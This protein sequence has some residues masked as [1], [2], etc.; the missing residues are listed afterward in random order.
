MPLVLMQR[1]WRD[2]P[3]YKDTE[4]VVYHYP[5]M[6]FDEIRGREEF[7][8]YRPA[9]GAP[10]GHGSTY[11]GCGV[12]GDWY[13]D[14]YDPNHRYVDIEKAVPFARPVPFEDTKGAMFESQLPSRNA[15]QGRS[16]RHIGELDFFRI[17]QA[18]GLTSAVFDGAPTVGDVLGGRAS[19]LLVPPRDAFRPLAVVPEGTGYRPNENGRPDIF[20][21]ASLQERARADHQETLKLFKNLVDGKGGTCL[22]NNNVDLLAS[23][24]EQRLLVE[25]K[26]LTRPVSTVD[27]MRYG[28]G[29]LFDYS[30]RY[31]AEIGNARPVLAFGSRLHDGVAWVAEIL[32]GNDVAFVAR[33]GSHLTPANDLAR[34]LPIFR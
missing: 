33:D 28:M 31:R 7:V 3:K 6:Y 2:D 27:R 34:N 8:Y 26:S 14:P 16:V 22:Y 4:F 21:A 20:E 5:R 1:A 24:G 19:P 11:F 10:R 15:F 30:V 32:Q 18:A 13:A 17:L 29:Q 23:F 25:V 9:R 12:L